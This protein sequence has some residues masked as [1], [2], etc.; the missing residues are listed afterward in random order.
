VRRF[1]T[2]VKIGLICSFCLGACSAIGYFA[3]L[4]IFPFPY[5]SIETIHYSKSI[6]DKDGNM[7]RSFTNEKDSWLM[8]VELD[9][10]NPDFIKATLAIEDKRFFKHPGIDISAVARAIKLNITNKRVISGASTVSMQVIRMLRK[11]DRTIFNKVIEAVHAIHLESLFTKEETL[12]LYFEIA[13]YGG[14]I[15]G[16]KAASLKYFQKDPKDLS[17]SECALLAGLPQSPTYLRPDRYSKRAET[18]RNKVLS[19]MLKNGYIDGS[20]YEN[21][22]HDSVIADNYPFPFEAAHFARFVKNKFNKSKLVTTLDSNI[23]HFAQL[24]LEEKI[25]ELKPYGVT[26]GAI[27]VIENK[28]GAVRAL[29][30]S[31]DF[32]SEENSGQINGALSRRCPGSTLKP[33]TYALG[34]EKGFYTPRMMLSDVPVQY[35]GYTPLDYDKKY[36][37]L[38]T[39]EEA[40][41]DSLNIPAVEV[42][43]KVGYRNLYF[44][45]ESLGISTLDKAPEHYG[46]SLTLGSCEVRLLELVNA[47]AALA[48]LGIYMPVKYLEDSNPKTLERVLSEASSYL[49]A[50]I[51]SDTERLKAI[52]IYRNDNIHPK[53]AWK[54]GTSYDHKDAWTISYN[55]EYTVGV[56]LGNFSGKS[57]NVLVG[58]ETAA[59]VAIRIFDWLYANKTAPWY[60]MPNTIGERYVCA[61]SGEPASENCE[62]QVKDLYIKRFSAMRKC[63]LH[64]NIDVEAKARVVLDKNKPMI[65]SPSNRCEYFITGIPIDEQK[66]ALTASG[67]TGA[68]N[69]YWFID[70]KFYDKSFAG[71]KLFWGMAQGMHT[72]TCSDNFGR[73]SS[74]TIVVR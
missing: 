46:L 56:W 32:F 44:F 9:E 69:L 23:Q 64:N 3:I 22:V 5:D 41:V 39:V 6:Y 33:F 51:L 16:V 57:S 73:S 34:I 58:V 1:K 62:H 48:R 37:G 25:D 66:L 2:L 70:N 20:Q 14:N 45:L 59:P 18:R 49:I 65:V 35:S 54:T 11:R 43:N 4:K 40:L 72:I 10:I 71:E 27:V 17:L 52:G 60:E 24:S 53:V 67:A 19:S 36:R 12:K 47:Y 74:V 42:L 8:P 30:G 38:V 7:L 21:E 29:V 13:P 68:D 26:N 50:D 28:T 55:P 31:V 63:R 61:L 15:H